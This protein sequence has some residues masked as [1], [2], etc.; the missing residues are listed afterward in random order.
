MFFECG[1]FSELIIF[2][3]LVFFSDFVDVIIELEDVFFR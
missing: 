3:F 2:K 1:D